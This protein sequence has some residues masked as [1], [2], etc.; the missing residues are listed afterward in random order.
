GLLALLID[1][2]KGVE[3]R[4]QGAQ[5]TIEKCRGTLQHRRHEEAERTRRRYD[6]RKHEGDLNPAIERHGTSLDERAKPAAGRRSQLLGIK[7]RIDEVDSD[8][9]GD[10]AAEYEIEHD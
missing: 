3:P 10:G 8:A 7:Q 6:E 9:D 1:A 5:T 4:F 2:G